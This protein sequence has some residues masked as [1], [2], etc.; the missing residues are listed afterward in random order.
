MK[1]NVF[2]YNIVKKL[3]V[4]FIVGICFVF[5]SVV[6]EANAWAQRSSSRQSS[7]SSSAQ[8]RQLSVPDLSFIG[9]TA[10]LTK[11]SRAGLE[12]FAKEISGYDFK[13]IYIE[14]YKDKGD[15]ASAPDEQLYQARVREVYNVL[16][17][18]GVSSEKM[19]Y[20]RLVSR[21]TSNIELSVE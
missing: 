7:R 12:T 6:F 2:S 20:I 3:S 14:L 10:E 8:R 19:K 1:R 18:G 9:N 17:A 4:V 11:T 16:K 5:T 15:S 13:Y 21:V